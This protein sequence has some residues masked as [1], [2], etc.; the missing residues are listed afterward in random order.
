MYGIPA[1]VSAT[2]F[3]MAVIQGKG[4]CAMPIDAAALFEKLGLKLADERPI[5]QGWREANAAW[6]RQRLM[7]IAEHAERINDHL[8]RFQR[9]PAYAS[10]ETR[11]A[12]GRPRAVWCIE[13]HSTSARSATPPASSAA[14]QATSARRSAAA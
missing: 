6:K 14:S 5:M 4:S 13:L 8:R 10:P 2:G 9:R 1:M 12:I 3:T 7:R 11:A